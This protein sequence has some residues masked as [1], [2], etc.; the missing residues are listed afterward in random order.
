MVQAPVGQP[1]QGLLCSR[2]YSW[3]ISFESMVLSHFLAKSLSLASTLFRSSQRSTRGCSGPESQSIKREGG[4][5][6]SV[7]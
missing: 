3:S 4:Q 7:G 5:P 2:E 6:Q 1:N